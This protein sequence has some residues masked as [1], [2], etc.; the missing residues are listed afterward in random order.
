MWHPCNVSVSVPHTEWLTIPD[1]VDILGLTQSQIR[2]SIEDNALVAMKVDSVL[3]VPAEFIEGNHLIPELKG[4]VILLRDCGFQDEEIISWLLTEE[5]NLEATPINAL[6]S[7]RKSE[8]R[9]VAQ[10]LL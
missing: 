5:D 8:V 9:R 2:R 10:A 6:K 3:K 1:L 7:G 4:T